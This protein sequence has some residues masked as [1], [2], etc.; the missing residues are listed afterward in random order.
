MGRPTKPKTQRQ[1]KLIVFRTTVAFSK[2]LKKRAEQEGKTLG[3]YIRDVLKR[4]IE[5]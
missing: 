5:R 3:T 2:A 4:E 1:T